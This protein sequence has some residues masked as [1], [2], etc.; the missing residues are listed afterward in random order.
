M[1]GVRDFSGDV[2]IH[3]FYDRTPPY[4]DTKFTNRDNLEEKKLS[5]RNG[6]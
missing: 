5:D 3:H 4:L 6:P 1:L 2:K